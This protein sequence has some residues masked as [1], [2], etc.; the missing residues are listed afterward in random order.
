MVATARILDRASDPE[1]SRDQVRE[2]AK[3][4]QILDGARKVFLSDGFDGASMNDIARAAGVSKG[5]LYAYFDSKEALFQA[6]V[7]NE[8]HGQAERVCSFATGEAD[9]V[10]TLRGVGRRM[11]EMLTQPDN[12]AILRMV[13]GVVGKFPE[14]GRAFYEAGPKFGLEKLT[15]YL[16]QQ[17]AA[18]LLNIQDTATAASNFMNLSHSEIVKSQMFGMVESVSSEEIGKSIENAIDIFMRAYAPTDK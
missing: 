4:H 7:R 8:K 14:I 3:L 1:A 10:T 13:I 5:T 18:G 9:I 17:V 12:V 6:L 15:L 11:V 2:S 16:D